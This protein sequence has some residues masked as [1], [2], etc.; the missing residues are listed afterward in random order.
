MVP[1]PAP[2]SVSRRCY[3][4]LDR[5]TTRP[6]DAVAAVIGANGW[7][8]HYHLFLLTNLQKCWALIFQSNV[9]YLDNVNKA[10]NGR[11]CSFHHVSANGSIPIDDSRRPTR[12]SKPACHPVDMGDT[13]YIYICIYCVMTMY[14]LSRV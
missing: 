1:A 6:T 13:T 9:P 10:E 3:Q 7:D 4:R 14:E 5:P 12:E 11:L 2:S 8:S